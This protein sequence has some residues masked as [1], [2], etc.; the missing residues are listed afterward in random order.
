MDSGFPVKNWLVVV[1][2]AFS[3]YLIVD[4]INSRAPEKSNPR[5]VTFISEKKSLSL[6]LA[7]IRQQKISFSSPVSQRQ[8]FFLKRSILR[9]SIK[10]LSPSSDQNN[11][12]YLNSVDWDNAPSKDI[13]KAESVL[14]KHYQV[15][16]DELLDQVLSDAPFAEDLAQAIRSTGL[17][18]GPPY[19]NL[20]NSWPESMSQK[21]YSDK[22]EDITQ[23]YSY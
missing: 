19:D 21:N 14:K 17:E 11:I 18:L 5:I 4:A 23:S 9:C 6:S 3:A 1:I 8:A 20:K 13:E 7:I 12:D 16:A 10:H 15:C 22:L 2:F